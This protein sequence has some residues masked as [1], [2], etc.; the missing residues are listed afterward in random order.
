MHIQDTVNLHALTLLLLLL[1]RA[2]L[3]HMSLQDVADQCMFT[4]MLILT[5]VLRSRVVT[6]V[7]ACMPLPNS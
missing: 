4:L 6:A 5:V 3:L 7:Q 2:N 1:N